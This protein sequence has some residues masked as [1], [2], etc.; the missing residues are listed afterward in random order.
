[1]N[2]LRW[3]AQLFALVMIAMVM[4]GLVLGGFFGCIAAA[5]AFATTSKAVALGA[6]FAALLSGLVGL[7]G[8]MCIKR[9]IFVL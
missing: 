8:L 2:V 4:G 7:T 3:I 5:L 1:M 6:C 9:D